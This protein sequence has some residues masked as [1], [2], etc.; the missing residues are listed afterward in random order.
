MNIVT[1]VF[2]IH[3]VNYFIFKIEGILRFNGL[4]VF[5]QI[6]SKL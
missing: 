1:K 5:N 4:K 3:P 6:I 2:L